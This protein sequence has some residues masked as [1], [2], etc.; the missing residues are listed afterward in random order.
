[1]TTPV[2]VGVRRRRG[3][4]DGAI[5]RIGLIPERAVEVL[6]A[7]LNLIPTPVPQTLFAPPTARVVQVGVS[8]GLFERLARGGPAR[9]DALARELGL[10]PAGTRLL[11]ECLAAMGHLRVGRDGRY[12]LSRRSRPWLDPASPR[13]VTHF[14]AHSATY[15]PWWEQLEAL[16]RDG[17]N[18]ELHDAGPEDPSWETYIRAQFELARLS[19]PEV[20]KALALPPGARSLLDVAGGHGWFGAAIAERHPGLHA[21]VVDLPGSAAVGRR[22]LQEHGGADRVTHVDGSAFATDLGGPHDAAL[23]FNLIHHLEPDAIVALFA[24][25]HAALA[26]GATLA[27]LDL[28]ARP[29]GARGGRDSHGAFLGL[30]FHLTSGADVYSAE[31]LHGFLAAAGFGPPRAVGLRRIPAQTLFLAPRR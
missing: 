5:A 22:I 10:Q 27:V 2:H 30:F 26:P 28:F 8:T 4:Q 18:V 3:R 31:E 24:R 7:A 12:R 20:A 13:S 9:G 11:C 25:I 16:V 1:M 14:V 23:V 17:R 19:A 21:T 29:R 15:W 6:G